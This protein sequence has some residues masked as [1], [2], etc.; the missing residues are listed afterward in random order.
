M[1]GDRVERFMRDVVESP[2]MRLHSD[3]DY[4][5]KGLLGLRDWAYSQLPVAV[6]DRVEL[7]ADYKPRGQF[8][9]FLSPGMH[10]VVTEIYLSSGP[11]SRWRVSFRADHDAS[12]YSTVSIDEVAKL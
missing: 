7:I 10:G 8:K 11:P 4:D 1:I 6:G 12:T 2:F 3:I 9:G 5:L